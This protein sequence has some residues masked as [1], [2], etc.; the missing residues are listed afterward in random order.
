MLSV[1]ERRGCDAGAAQDGMGAVCRC[2]KAVLH[3]HDANRRIRKLCRAADLLGYGGRRYEPLALTLPRGKARPVKSM[4]ALIVWSKTG[5]RIERLIAAVRLAASSGHS[6]N[7]A[8]RR[9]SM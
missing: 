2:R 9:L 3:G 7:P 1:L 4:L 5:H 6:G 8:L